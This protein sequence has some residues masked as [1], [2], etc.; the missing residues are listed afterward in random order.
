V[1]AV[2]RY[3]ESGVLVLQ[4]LRVNAQAL[5]IATPDGMAQLNALLA[6]DRSA[7]AFA[8]PSESLSFLEHEVSKAERKVLAQSLPFSLEDR[9]AQD[10]DELHFAFRWIADDRVSVAVVSKERMQE[11]SQEPAIAKVSQ[12]IPDTLLLPHE[13]GQWVVVIEDSRCF[14][15]LS[16]SSAFVCPLDLLAAFLQSSQAQV[17]PERILVFSASES[18]LPVL[19]AELENKVV[20]RRG[21]WLDAAIMSS[22]WGETLNLRQG[23]FVTVLPWVSWWSQWRWVAAALFAGVAVQAGVTFA[24]LQQAEQVNLELR[25]GIESRYREAYPQGAMVDP[26]KQLERQLLSLRGDGQRSGFVSLL[27]RTGLALQS[28]PDTQMVTLNYSDRNEQLSITILAADFS[29]VESIRSELVKGGLKAELDSSSAQG[30]QVRARL[31]VE[32]NG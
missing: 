16:E 27:D 30:D 19:P 6:E 18:M 23:D 7:V 20:S 25:Q 12:W 10:I 22:E 13:V 9:L 15:R 31:K 4:Y 14:V 5:P 2:L 24:G 29:A 1:K 32:A 11:W 21:A 28:I 8:V 26:Q 17:A 3:D